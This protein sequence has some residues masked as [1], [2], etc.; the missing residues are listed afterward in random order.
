MIFIVLIIVSIRC[1]NQ[2]CVLCTTL[3]S[4]RFEV[5]WKCLQEVLSVKKT[6]TRSQVMLCLWTLHRWTSVFMSMFS[7]EI[8]D[9]CLISNMLF[10]VLLSR[11]PYRNLCRD[12]PVSVV[13]P[14][15][16]LLVPTVLT[17]T[18]FPLEWCMRRSI[19]VVYISTCDYPLLKLKYRQHAARR[20]STPYNKK[21]LLCHSQFQIAFFASRWILSF[22]TWTSPVG[23]GWALWFILATSAMKSKS[24]TF[25]R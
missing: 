8:A 7:Y 14:I 17:M 12:R 13:W 5:S 15:V 19:L 4:G 11:I 21:I 1:S 16:M 25:L 10:S 22:C 18:F 2:G 3:K 23:A 9:V 20:S 6:H 24:D